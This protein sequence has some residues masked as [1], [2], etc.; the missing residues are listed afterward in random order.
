M[1][2]PELIIDDV[3]ILRVDSDTYA[4]PPRAAV[5]PSAFIP[6]TFTLDL[7]T[8]DTAPPL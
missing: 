7:L 5:L 3:P 1:L 2:A 4:N 6:S 8:I